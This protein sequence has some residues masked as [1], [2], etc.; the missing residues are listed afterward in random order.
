MITQCGG[1]VDRG[2]RRSL[3]GHL[4]FPP[5]AGSVHGDGG[6]DGGGHPHHADHPRAGQEDFQRHH[7]ARGAHAGTLRAAGLSG[8]LL[9][10][11]AWFHSGSAVAFIDFI[12]RYK[13]QAVLMLA[14]IAVYRISECDG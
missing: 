9:T 3:R 2:E 7:R 10:A 13:W 8:W 5:L 12:Q 11:T 1:A 14:L 6:A 4:R